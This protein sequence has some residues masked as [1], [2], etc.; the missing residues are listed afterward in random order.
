MSEEQQEYSPDSGQGQVVFLLKR[1][2]E[3]VTLLERKVD[4]LIAQS[5]DKEREQPA[6]EQERG[7]K[8]PPFRPSYNSHSRG[9][10]RYEGKYEGNKYEGKREGRPAYGSKPT[11]RPSYG[12]S[13]PF[14]A[15]FAGKKKPFYKKH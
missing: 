3:Q 2:Q 6:Y 1:L 9:E 15:G 7:Y 8:K 10:G 14:G 5:K 11:G 4:T 12:P 13:K